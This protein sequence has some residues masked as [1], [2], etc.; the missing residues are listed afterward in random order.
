MVGELNLIALDIG[1]GDASS[2]VACCVAAAAGVPPPSAAARLLLRLLLIAAA[3][4]LCTF[5][6]SRFVPCLM[7]YRY[8]FR[9]V[10]RYSLG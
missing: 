6:D 1:D 9:L 7:I 10:Y 2:A 8:L 5:D 3:L 4:L